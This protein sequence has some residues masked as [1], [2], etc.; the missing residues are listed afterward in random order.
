MPVL[1][2]DDT[3]DRRVTQNLQYKSTFAPLNMQQ[4]T[5][6][7]E[8][9]TKADGEQPTADAEAPAEATP[10]RREEVKVPHRRAGPKSSKPQPAGSNTT[11]PPMNIPTPKHNTRSNRLKSFDDTIESYINKDD[12]TYEYDGRD[13]IDTNEW[14][15]LYEPCYIDLS[16]DPTSYEMF[17]EMERAHTSKHT[18]HVTQEGT[19]F[20]KACKHHGIPFEFHDQYHLWL[21]LTQHQIDIEHIPRGRGQYLKV[22]IKL[23]KPGGSQWREIIATKMSK[24][25]KYQQTKL[26]KSLIDNALQATINQ[27]RMEACLGN[28]NLPN[29]KALHKAKARVKAQREK[30]IASGQMAPP[31]NMS[32]AFNHPT[33]GHL[34]ADAA[35]SEWEGL[36]DLGVLKHGYTIEEIHDMGIPPPINLSVGFVIKTKNNIFERCKVRCCLAGHKGNMIK[37]IHFDQTFAASPNQH[38]MRLLQSLLVKHKWFRKS[39]DIKQ[40]YLHAGLDPSQYVSV[41]Y[42][43]GFEQYKRNKDGEL[44][45]D[46]QG[47]PIPLYAIC[48]KN[49]YGHPSAS[50]GWTKHRDKFILSTFNADITKPNPNPDPDHPTIT[51][52]WTCTRPLMDPCLFKFI[53]HTVTHNGSLTS[54]S[55]G[56]AL[57]YTDDVDMI[58]S[59]NDIMEDIYE[60]MDKE[61]GVNKVSS[62]VV[63]G[64]QRI[65]SPERDTVT[66]TMSAYIDTMT[67]MFSEHLPKPGSKPKQTP[68]PE[69]VFLSKDDK[70]V[71]DDEAKRVLQRG[72]QRVIGC[73]LWVARNVFCMCLTGV[74]MLCRV[75]SRPSELAWSAAI[76]MMAWLREN[77]EIGIRFSH[78][79][80]MSPINFVD[81]SNKPDPSDGKAQYGYC[82]M[83]QGGPVVFVSKK[84][85][86]VGLNAFHNEYMAMCEAAK[87]IVWLRQ[88]LAE[89]GEHDSISHPTLSYGDNNAALSLSVE[90]FVSTGNQYVY[91]PYH[92]VKEVS[93]MGY[94]N[95]Q[96]KKSQFNLADVFTKPVTKTVLGTLLPYL[97]GLRLISTEN[98]REGL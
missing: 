51:Y 54:K 4:A 76:H 11:S 16:T 22:G 59:D 86:H 31:R 74:S 2:R 29:F 19:S 38:S 71:T 92:Y 48:V 14:C 12:T 18:F 83:I 23:P 34:W 8:L 37:G 24:F 73:L 84:L 47:K 15:D 95:F 94:V 65:L 27:I 33:M 70:S 69:T 96:P 43:A 98:M 90:D 21:C 78:E 32:E 30:A 41:K 25:D 88:L 97:C 57:I 81:A 20:S 67:E 82:T 87:S 77:K 63:L 53:R 1:M 85:N 26:Q 55:E 7:E 13:P 75:M 93:R 10:Q 40:A 80:N 39:W 17:E 79:G 35:Y 89:L 9:D 52:R 6:E 62:D 91:L 3:R 64:V 66:L 61:W 45:L 68:F 42:P 60:V 44:V 56:I 36:T 49:I 5:P 50:R 46:G 72:Y 58:A 28:K